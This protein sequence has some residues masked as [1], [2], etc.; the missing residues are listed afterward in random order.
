MAQWGLHSKNNHLSIFNLFILYFWH[1][2]SKVGISALTRVQQ[3]QMDE[4]PRE[5]IAVNCVHPGYVRTDLTQ[6][7][8]DKS[9]EEG[10]H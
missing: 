6:Q 7:L 3:R 9:I 10:I 1:K 4:D 8:G 5:D 2:V